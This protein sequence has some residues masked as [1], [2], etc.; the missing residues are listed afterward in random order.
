M[1]ATRPCATGRWT[2]RRPLFNTRS[3][4]RNRWAGIVSSHLS[5]GM[6]AWWH[7]KRTGSAGSRSWRPFSSRPVHAPIHGKRRHEARSKQACKGWSFLPYPQDMATTAD[8]V[9]A[10]RPFRHPRSTRST[11]P[12]GPM[13]FAMAPDGIVATAMRNLPERPLPWQKTCGLPGK[14]AKGLR[15]SHKAYPC[16]SAGYSRTGSCR[17]SIGRRN[18]S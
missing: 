4:A 6:A 1:A 8:T 15:S 17:H 2:A 9:A 7:W 5:G 13:T 3:G 12:A 11:P 18:R 16:R 10:M 14:C